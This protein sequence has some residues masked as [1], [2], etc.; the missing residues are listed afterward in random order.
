MGQK[1]ENML[2]GPELFILLDQ[3]RNL[4]ELCISM[5]PKMPSSATPV[6]PIPPLNDLSTKN[7]FRAIQQRLGRKLEKLCMSFCS[8]VWQKPSQTAYTIVRHLLKCE[9][10]RELEFNFVRFCAA[11]ENSSGTA[12][13]KPH[14]QPLDQV[15]PIHWLLY[16]VIAGCPRLEELS[17]VGMQLNSTQA[18]NLGLQIRNRWKGTSLRIHIWRTND[19]EHITAEIIFNLLHALKTDS[20]FEADYIGGYRATIL[21]R[22]PSHLCGLVSR[23]RDMKTGIPK[24]LPLLCPSSRDLRASGSNDLVENGTESDNIEELCATL[25]PRLR[26]LFGLTP[27][28]YSIM[29]A[30]YWDSNES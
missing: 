6:A 22:R 3:L 28:D 21:V 19:D 18:Y 20:K 12:A 17:L 11:A 24:L 2:C 10:L 16:A 13:L 4:R 25:P 29:L 27:F 1:D 5:K 15:D 14:Q 23:F 7:F 30:Q 26:S 9:R 8:I